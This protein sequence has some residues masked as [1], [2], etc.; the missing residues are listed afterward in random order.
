MIKKILREYEQNINNYLTELYSGAQEMQI[1]D[2]SPLII[3][4]DLH[5]GDG[6]SGDDFKKN[7]S[8]FNE[9]LEKYYNSKNFT[10]VLNGD[11]EELQKFRINDIR[12]Q[13]HET[14]GIFDAFAKE[15]R[16]IKI[17]GNHDDPAGTGTRD[18]RYDEK[19][20]VKFRAEN[21]SVPIFIYHGH[22]ASV[23][24]RHLNRLNTILLRY[25]VNPL[26]IKN[27]T[28]KFRHEKKIRIENRSYRFSRNNQLISI[29]GHTHRPLFESMS[30]ADS[31]H[32]EIENL[33][34]KYRKANEKKRIKVAAR[35]KELKTKYNDCVNSK[36]EYEPASLMYSSGIPVP[37]LFNTGC[38]IGKRG[39]TGLEI[40]S[41]SIALVHWFDRRISNKFLFDSEL[42]T[43]VLETD[44]PMHRVVLRKD[45]LDYISD[46]INLLGGSAPEV[47]IKNPEAKVFFYK[48][49]DNLTFEC[50][51]EMSYGN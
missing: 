18:K 19:E 15:N 49:K 22:Q 16:L 41:D 51:D 36:P 8:L 3:F 50:N 21:S 38:A 11:I 17:I 2:E 25:I 37:C 27:F 35:I 45:R 43:E 48:T 30:R 33:L 7:G 12:I 5:M 14:F 34:R 39:I 28:K 9:V 46:S 10:L 4:S 1:T 40:T 23:Y 47:K 32:F 31:L 24:Y 13:W 42:E 20:A 29:I 6:R 26:R 44:S